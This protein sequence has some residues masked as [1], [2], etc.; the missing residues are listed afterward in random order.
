MSERGGKEANQ[1]RFVKWA[2]L[3]LGVGWLFS[4]SLAYAQS[5]KPKDVSMP[6]TMIVCGGVGAGS[7][8]T[9]IALWAVKR[10]N[11]VYPDIAIRHIPGGNKDGIVKA[12]EGTVGL[13]KTEAGISKR[14]WNGL[15]PEFEGK[16]LRDA[17]II[18]NVPTP[19]CIAMATLKNR[20]DINTAKDLWNKKVGVGMATSI[21]HVMAQAALGAYGITP[22]SIKKNGGVWGYGKWEQQFE[23]LSTGTLDVVIMG[24]PQPFGPA[25]TIDKGFGKGI[26]LVPWGAE[27]IAAQQK[28][29]PDNPV[30]TI[31][32]NVY[33]GQ[34][35]PIKAFGTSNL[36]AVNKSMP[37]GVV[38]NL[39]Y[40]LFKDDGKSY[41]EISAEFK[42]LDVLEDAVSMEPIPWHPGAVQYWRERKMMK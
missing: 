40:A 23:M 2:V 7:T 3:G 12:S 38:Y 1:M 22:E 41:H 31:P 4:L 32:A 33:S 27:G 37:D 34:K 8:S 16:P 25:L 24:T 6:K 26:K 29:Y 36:F 35:E 14:A 9:L 11:A 30:R 15:P 28:K 10:I 21:T 20:D 5:V 42:D 39:L 19:T 13:G 17:R 18:T